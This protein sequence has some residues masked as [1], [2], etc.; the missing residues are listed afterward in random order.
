MTPEYLARKLVLE[1]VDRALIFQGI[2]M[3]FMIVHLLFLI[4]YVSC[5]LSHIGDRLLSPFDHKMAGVLSA[6][7]SKYVCSVWYF[8]RASYIPVRGILSNYCWFCWKSLNLSPIWHSSVFYRTYQ[9]NCFLRLNFVICEGS[10]PR[11]FQCLLQHW[12]S[13]IRG[14]SVYDC[15]EIDLIH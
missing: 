6:N 7:L 9:R 10:G 11:N 1:L 8:T 4:L 2:L 12:I 5:S 15:E 13:R 14:E 3:D